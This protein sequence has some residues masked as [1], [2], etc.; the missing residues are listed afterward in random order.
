MHYRRVLKTGDPGPPGPLR[1]RGVCKIE[2]CDEEVDAKSLCHGHYQRVL[3]KSPI[4]LDEPLRRGKSMCK[5][6]ACDRKADKRGYCPAHYK[7]VL[8]HGHPQAD[9]PIR[10]VDG[11]GHMSHGYQQINVPKDLRHLSRGST[12]IA[13]HRFV[14]A[15]HLGRA[16]SPDE[17]VHHINGIKTDNRLENLELWSTSHPNGR[18]VEDLLEYCLAMLDRYGHEFGVFA[19]DERTF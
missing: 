17:H 13:E 16:L 4:P 14:M 2:D 5:V 10:K 7:R 1:S 3:R 18:R 15:E 9:I 11:S 6:E 19:P 8:K 12:K